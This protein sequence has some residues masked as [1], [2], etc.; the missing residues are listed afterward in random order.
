M[1]FM[2]VTILSMTW[3]RYKYQHNSSSSSF[4]IHFLHRLRH[5]SLQCFHLT[6]RTSPHPIWMTTQAAIKVKA[7]QTLH[8]NLL[9]GVEVLETLGTVLDQTL[10]F[11]TVT[12]H[13]NNSNKVNGKRLARLATYGTQHHP[14]PPSLPTYLK[15]HYSAPQH[16]KHRSKHHWMSQT[17]VG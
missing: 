8:V 11:Q 14:S 7:D 5:H 10:V 15:L 16:Y 6:K 2:H 4:L 13:N 3:A 17:R 1:R 9:N 12:I